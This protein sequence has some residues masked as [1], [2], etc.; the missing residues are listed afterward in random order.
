M[1]TLAV[2][3]LSSKTSRG[4]SA[5]KGGSVVIHVQS[6]S[7]LARKGRSYVTFGPVKGEGNS[8]IR[9]DGKEESEEAKGNAPEW[10]CDTNMRFRSDGSDQAIYF[11][12][13]GKKTFSK[14]PIF[15]GHTWLPLSGL[16]V[17]KED[18]THE[19]QL[20]SWSEYPDNEVSGTI[21]VLT[22]YNDAAALSPLGKA[23]KGE[24]NDEQK[25]EG[26]KEEKKEDREE[27]DDEDKE[28][29]SDSD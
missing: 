13:W 28:N 1:A 10:D 3:K 8:N 21:K 22:T 23:S 7:G 5:N 2:P 16:T 11:Q 25:K 18:E 29:S 26:E 4:D 14:K 24:S 12:V 19:L 9:V 27:K 17:G 15:L 20:K 6:G